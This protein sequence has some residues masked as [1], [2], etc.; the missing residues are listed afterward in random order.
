MK[1]AKETF[2]CCTSESFPLPILSTL[3]VIIHIT[4]SVLEQSVFEQQQLGK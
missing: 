4:W 1:T 3:L 2:D